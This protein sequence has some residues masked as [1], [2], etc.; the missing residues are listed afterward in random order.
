[1]NIGGVEIPGQLALGPMAGVTN[2]AF[3][4]TCRR[5]GAALTCTEMVSSRGLM[6]ND[7]KTEE[8]LFIFPEDHPS[9]AQIFGS[10]P[11]IMGEAAAKA[12][13]LSGANIIDINMGC[14]VGKVVRNG[15]GSA[16]MRKPELAARIIEA[17]VK[18]AGCPV[19]VKF[20]KGWD[21]GNVNAVAFAQMCEQAGAAAIAVHGRTRAQ[22]YGGAADWDI[23]RDVKQAVSI[24]VIG[25]GDIFT[26]E[27]A[28]RMKNRTGADMLMIGRGSFGDPWLFRRAAAALAGE[29]IPPDP[30][31]AARIDDAVAMFELSCGQKGEHLACLEARKQFAWY[32]RGVPWSGYIKQ[33][34]SHINTLEDIR[35][36]ADRAKRELR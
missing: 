20:R 34:I 30:P 9:A 14:P 24:P 5:Q 3:R 27:D 25:N 6:Y 15:D 32:F 19:T 22:L 35:R 13:E 10:E 17:C 2:A 18:Q 26:A 36:I 8:L 1:M 33:E 11:E 16:L 31:L 23:L 28:A 7:R 12:R 29:E 21:G 4:L